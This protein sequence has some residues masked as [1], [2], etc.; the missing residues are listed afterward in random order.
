[1]HNRLEGAIANVTIARGPG[2][3]PQVGFVSAAGVFRQRQNLE[4]VRSNGLEVEASARHGILSASTSYAL[5][6]ARVEADG[7]AAVLDGRRPAQTPRHQVSATLGLAPRWGELALTVRHLGA[8]AED[9]LGERRLPPA[10]TLDLAARVPV[11]KRLAF[12]ARAENLLN[13]EVV[14]G[15]SATGIRDLAQPRT[16]WAGATLVY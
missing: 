15:V 8:Q 12:V 5:T 6:L 1:F 7:V 9:D 14:S 10:T 2:T 13:E 3:F 11:G 16:L 4:A